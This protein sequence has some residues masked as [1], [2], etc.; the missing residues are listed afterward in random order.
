[1]VNVGTLLGTNISP[2]KALLKRIF[3]FPRLDMLVSWRVYNIPYMD[4]MGY[5][6]EDLPTYKTIYPCWVFHVR[7]LGHI[8]GRWWSVG[9]DFVAGDDHQIAVAE[10]FPSKTQ[11]LGNSAI[12]TFFGDCEFMWFFQ[13]FL[14]TSKKSGMNRSR[15]ESPGKRNTFLNWPLLWKLLLP[16]DQKWRFQNWMMKNPP[17]NFKQGGQ[18]LPRFSYPCTA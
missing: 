8:R 9:E 5:I 4:P 14:M 16:F 1:M 6:L 2:T 3:L 15:L 17:L 11:N 10:S 7:F 12:V 18:G 13:R